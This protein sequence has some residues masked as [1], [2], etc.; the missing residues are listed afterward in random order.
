MKP[1]AYILQNKAI[2][3]ARAQLEK[4]GVMVP[5]DSLNAVRAIAGELNLGVQSISRLTLQQR[6]TLIDRLNGMGA[7]VRN[8]AIYKS[9][10]DAERGT[11]GPGKEQKRVFV[12]SEASEPQLKM[13]DSMAARVRWNEP[14]GYLRFCVKQIKCTRPMNNRQVTKLRCALLSLIAQQNADSGAPFENPQTLV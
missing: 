3:E 13:L 14:D 7:R 6:R 9:D 12:Y 10:Y 4:L 2:H 1:R 5:G 8:P 11:V